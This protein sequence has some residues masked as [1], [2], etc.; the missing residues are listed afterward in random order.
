MVKEFGFVVMG[1]L[2]LIAAWTLVAAWRQPAAKA[3]QKQWTGEGAPV[4]G[5]LKCYINLMLVAVV[6]IEVWGLYLSITGYQTKPMAPAHFMMILG[7]VVASALV[8][9]FLYMSSAQSGYDRQQSAARA[10][11]TNVG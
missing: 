5:G 9:I 10:G 3:L 4:K 8:S 1:A 2:T 6:A 11:G 7:V